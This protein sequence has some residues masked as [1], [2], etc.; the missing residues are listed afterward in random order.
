MKLAT[1]TVLIGSAVAFAPS[2]T[3]RS[4]TSLAIGREGNVELG[5]NTWKPDSEK[6][7]STVSWRCSSVLLFNFT[8]CSLLI[9]SRPVPFSLELIVYSCPQDTGDYFPEGY[10]PEA[11]IAFTSGMGGSQA[12]NQE[13]GG[14]QLPGM[15]NLGADA[16]VTG[17]IEQAEDI[18]DGM[19][20][21]MDQF[22]PPTEVEMQV[23]ASSSGSDIVLSVAPT[24]M[25]FED[26]FA[27]FTSDSHSSFSVDPAV[28]R[29]D[30]RGGETTELTV[31]CAPNGQSGNFEAGLVVNLPEDGSTI[32]YKIKATVF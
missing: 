9:I 26:Y 31:T 11:E 24:C 8:V 14:P 4:A 29:M 25:T 18:P 23:A 28:G 21:E 12:S 32:C 2:L 17:G 22:P 19:T 16:V 30:R 3:C 10:D 27:G 13:R 15:E 20:F 7:G 5:G 1:S 6:M